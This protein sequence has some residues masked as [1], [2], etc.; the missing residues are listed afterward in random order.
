M[1]DSNIYL[2]ILLISTL[3]YSALIVA[4]GC[5]SVSDREDTQQLARVGNEYL[6]IKEARNRIP[7]FILEEDS[8]S[9][10]RSFRERW[11]EKRLMLQEAERLQLRQR[12]EV[13]EKLGDARDEV[14]A[15][16]LKDVVISNF[17]EDLVVT[18]EE[19]RN[20]YQAHKEQF[21]L[22]ERFVQFRH[23]IARDIE[24]ARTAKRE[25]M[26]AV[27]WPEVARSHSIN[28]EAQI[29]ES[30]QYWPISMALADIDIMNRY[31]QIIGQTEISPIQRVNGNYHFVQLMDARAEGEHPELDWLIEQIKDWL[32]LDK[33]R[34]H[35]SSYVKNL[36][37]K[38]ESNNEIETFNVLPTHSNTKP[39]STDTLENIQ[40][41]E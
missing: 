35:L 40:T 22:N 33:R 17:E 12:A 21:V 13:Q 3:L 39:S 8:I 23:L 29:T 31:L 10:L 16:A 6:T 36:Y 26:Q 15:Q 27:P 20:Y 28:P 1:I 34:R 7:E 11:I 25:L 19:A 38:A 37:L 32:A 4:T 5:R 2:R 18:D 24:S 41:N 14:L 30:E 9:A